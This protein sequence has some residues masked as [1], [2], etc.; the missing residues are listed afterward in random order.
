MKLCLENLER[1]RDFY[2][3]K[4]RDIEVDFIML[5]DGDKNMLTFMNW[6][7]WRQGRKDQKHV[8]WARLDSMQMWSMTDNEL[9]FEKVAMKI[10]KFI[11]KIFLHYNFSPGDHHFI[12][13]WEGRVVTEDPWRALRNRGAFCHFVY[14][15]YSHFQTILQWNMISTCIKTRMIY[16]PTK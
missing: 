9:C 3:G 8:S 14:S 5:K 2:F 16:T 6:E 11:K 12:G 15:V 10:I 13:R 4:L 1:E 7:I